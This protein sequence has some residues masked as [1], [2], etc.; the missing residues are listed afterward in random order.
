MVQ[1]AL[2]EIEPLIADIEIAE[3]T[4]VFLKFITTNFSGSP[5]VVRVELQGN[6]E[7]IKNDLR[8]DGNLVLF[9]MGEWLDY[10]F[11]GSIIRMMNSYD[12]T[13]IRSSDLPGI[14][15]ED[16]PRGFSIYIGSS[17]QLPAVNVRKINYKS[18]C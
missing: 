7:I 18:D 11:P 10:H 13:M 6:S 16:P 9:R 2:P 17:G 15:D 1:V 14:I 4:C 5:I 3:Q 12:D 8:D